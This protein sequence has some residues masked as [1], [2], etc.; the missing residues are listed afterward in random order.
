MAMTVGSFMGGALSKYLY[1]NQSCTKISLKIVG[2]SGLQAAMVTVP[3]IMIAAFAAYHASQERPNTDEN[4]RRVYGYIT[5]IPTYFLSGVIFTLALKVFMNRMGIPMTYKEAF[6]NFVISSIFAVP[7][8]LYLDIPLVNHFT[9]LKLD[10]KSKLPEG[11]L[12]SKVGC[13]RDKQRGDGA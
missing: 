8:S 2:L 5:A 4:Q 11:D 6:C 1:H 7:A 12:A 3:S 9:N 13:D 10:V